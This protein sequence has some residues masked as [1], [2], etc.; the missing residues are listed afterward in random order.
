MG[1]R[2]LVR[3]IDGNQEILCIY[4][5]FDG[6]PDGLGMDIHAALV[7]RQL[8][9]GISM[10]RDKCANGMGDAAALLL[11]SLKD[12]NAGNVYV[13]APGTVDVGEEYTYVLKETPDHE[14]HLTI[15]EGEVTFFGMS[16]PEGCKPHDHIPIYAGLLVDFAPKKCEQKY[17]RSA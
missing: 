16:A 9:N 5:Q 7:H 2:A 15:Y 14:F 12:D 4:R 17:H 13:H 1:T 3:V 8:V 10:D 6:Y 11:R